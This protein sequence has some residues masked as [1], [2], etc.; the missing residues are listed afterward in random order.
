MVESVVFCLIQ[1]TKALVI[2]QFGL[3]VLLNLSEAVVEIDVLNQLDMA[4]CLYV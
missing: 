3:L 1:S 4:S 2:F